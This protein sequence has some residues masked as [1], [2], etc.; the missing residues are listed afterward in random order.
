MKV[1]FLAQGNN[2]RL[3]S[4]SNTRLTAYK[5]ATHS[6]TWYLDRFSVNT[7]YSWSQTAHFNT[8]ESCYLDRLATTTTFCQSKSGL[9]RGTSLYIYFRK[10]NRKHLEKCRNMD[11]DVFKNST[12]CRFWILTK[13]VSLFLFLKLAFLTM[14]IWGIKTKT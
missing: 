8:F 14:H 2:G 4:C 10:W 13:L 7:A 6:T 12:S 11:N 1:K 3:W 5:S 9:F